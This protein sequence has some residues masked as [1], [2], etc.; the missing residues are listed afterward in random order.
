MEKRFNFSLTDLDVVAQAYEYF[1]QRVARSS[2]IQAVL[3]DPPMTKF[4]DY[5]RS[6]DL[7]GLLSVDTS[8][9]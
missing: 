1:V 6:N 2:S 7:V 3:L 8:T 4:C 9:E 5:E